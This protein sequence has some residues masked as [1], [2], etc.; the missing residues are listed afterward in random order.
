M[1]LDKAFS[2]N[3][4]NDLL[5]NR[6][7]NKNDVIPS[8]IVLVTKTSSFSRKQQCQTDLLHITVLQ[9]KCQKMKTVDAKKKNIDSLVE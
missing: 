6:N 3:L 8:Q 5:L 9:I 2:F 1:L 7:S 4:A